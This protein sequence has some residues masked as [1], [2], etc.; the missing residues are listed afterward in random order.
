MKKQTT[1]D[2][3]EKYYPNY[4]KSEEIARNEDLCKL[5]FEESQQGDSAD[6]ILEREFA[7]DKDNPQINV[8]Y[9]ESLVNIYETAIKNFLSTH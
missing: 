3:V 2:F 9:Q 6:A 7:G 4:H 5:V 8:A 1:W